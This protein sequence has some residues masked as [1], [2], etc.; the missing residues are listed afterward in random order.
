MNGRRLIPVALAAGTFAAFLPA[1]GGEFVNWDDRTNFLD[2]PHYRGLGPAQLVWMFTTF[3]NS[4]YQPLSWLTFGL[5]FLLWGENPFGYH[6]TN[7]L[8]HCANAALVYGLCRAVLSFPAPATLTQSQEVGGDGSMAIDFA[9]VAAAL[10][11]SLHPLR[12]EA[13]AWATERREL[14]SA[15][16]AILAARLYLASR[17]TGAGSLWWP[18]LAGMAAMSANVRAASLPLLLVILDFWPLRRWGGEAGWGERR[19]WAEKVPFAA[20]A[21]GVVILGFMAQSASRTLVGLADAP[22]ASRLAQAFFGV[23]FYPWKTLLPVGL[24][25]WYGDSYLVQRPWL[26]GLGA[27]LVVGVSGWLWRRRREAPGGAALWAAYL[28]SLLPTLGLVKS[29]R[30]IVAD[31]YSYLPA[32]ILALGAAAALRWAWR[33]PRR[34]AAAAALACAAPLLGALSWRQA[35]VWSDSVT[36]WSHAFAVDKRSAFIRTNLGIAFLHASRFREALA[37]FEDLRGRELEPSYRDLLSTLIAMTHNNW[38]VTASGAGD[39][40]AAI[41]HFRDAIPGNPQPEG[42]RHNLGLA[43]FKSGRLPEAVAEL[44]LVVRAAPGFVEAR[45]NF[46]HALAAAGRRREA[47]FELEEALRRDPGHARA[48]EGLAALSRPKGSPPK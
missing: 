8:L 27:G 33:S 31:R 26:V 46:G 19:I 40:E 39:F 7:L 21:S 2:N 24:S 23:A 13:V 11:F 35:G 32:A 44:E 38:G 14:L 28:V 48:Q 41:R 34:A 20:V 42:A 15:F 43:L 37:F 5:D 22:T 47:R 12:V 45:V 10:L 17:R 9:S 16:L 4:H 36:L 29:G 30:Q 1:L 25:P 6:L 3:H 18:L